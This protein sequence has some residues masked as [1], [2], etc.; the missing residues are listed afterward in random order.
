MTKSRRRSSAA[1]GELPR[2]ALQPQRE[3]TLGAGNSAAESSQLLDSRVHFLDPG[4]PD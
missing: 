2:A 3:A 1:A 4:H